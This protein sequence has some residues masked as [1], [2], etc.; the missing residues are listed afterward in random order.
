MKTRMKSNLVLVPEAAKL[1]GISEQR[2]H[3]LIQSKKIKATKLGRQWFIPKA[4][5]DKRKNK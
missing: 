4:E 2:V 5:I 1:L 3:Q